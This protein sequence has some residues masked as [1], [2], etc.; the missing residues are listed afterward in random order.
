MSY[1]DNQVSGQHK[2]T[3]D[4][5]DG[6]II[7]DHYKNFLMEQEVREKESLREAKKVRQKKKEKELGNNCGAT[8]SNTNITEAIREVSSLKKSTR[9]DEFH[10]TSVLELTKVYIAVHLL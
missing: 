8:T 9:T 7:N 5:N 6:D 4:K 1:S 3:E 2:E 10:R